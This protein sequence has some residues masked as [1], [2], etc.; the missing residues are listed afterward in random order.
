MAFEEAYGFSSKYVFID[1]FILSKTSRFYPLALRWLCK[2]TCT[3]KQLYL[4][5]GR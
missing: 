3:T 2:P 1:W 5:E 4:E